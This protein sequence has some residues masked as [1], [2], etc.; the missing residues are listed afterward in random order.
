MEVMDQGGGSKKMEMFTTK[1][2]KKMKGCW[3][4]T[5]KRMPRKLELNK[6]EKR[7]RKKK[8]IPV[9]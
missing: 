3:Y 6:N 1:S 8:K 4:E 7:G 5:M 9:L 2:L